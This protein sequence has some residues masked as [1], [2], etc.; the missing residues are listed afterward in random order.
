M[1][2]VQSPRRMAAF[3]HTLGGFGFW[4]A[5]LAASACCC[6]EPL[7]I[8][9]DSITAREGLTLSIT[10]VGG[11][12][13]KTTVA[14]EDGGGVANVQQY[15]RDVRIS[16]NG[17]ALPVVHSASGWTVRHAPNAIL[18]IRYRLPPS[19]PTR[20]AAGT[21]A[22][23]R[24]LIHNGL[25]HLV[26]R[27]ALVLPI[28]RAESDTV[29][30]DID[31]SQL[32]SNEHFVSSFGPG[33][34][35]QGLSVTREQVAAALYL[36]GPISLTLY[37][38][39]SGRVGIV[40]SAMAPGFRGDAMRA[41]ALHIVQAERRFF[42]DSQPWYLVSETGGISSNPL[43]HQGGGEGLT[44]S[45]VMFSASDTDFADAEQREQFRWV[46][47][48]EYFHQW[49]GLSLRVASLASTH[50]DDTSVYWFSEGVTEFYAMR[51]LTRAGLQSS[52]R[53]LDI[54]D[55]KLQRY[56]ANSKRGIGAVAAGRLFWSDPDAD[57]IPYLR[58]YLA[59][60]SIDIAL[61]RGSGGSRSLDTAMRALV[62]RAKAEP[63]FRVDNAFLVH[64]LTEGLAANDPAAFR[65]FVVDGG[66]AP[67]DANSFAPCLKGRTE[68]IDGHSTLQFHF[69]RPS[70]T[71]CFEH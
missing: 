65:K 62:S 43:I 33:S 28:G 67:L 46:L 56:A 23:F 60:W 44:H 25:F 12:N 13:G 50:E 32:V 37:E 39:P 42:N 30:L 15:V 59:A 21:A 36:G 18:T 26:G 1:L 3:L 35:L 20:I 61:R 47:S 17:H 31:A 4:V 2:P 6:A 24:P 53:S 7:K 16:T 51:L 9:F 8:H 22:Q 29:T 5:L 58:G 49:N 71:S 19:G 41:D 38:T 40:Y 66:E 14:N 55:N 11:G 63:S 57:Q 70:N 69:A 48:H 68:S 34:H 45:F 64:Y 52:K 27:A 54:L 10:T